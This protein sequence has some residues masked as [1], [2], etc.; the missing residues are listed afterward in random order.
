MTAQGEPLPEPAV[1]ASAYTQEYFLRD[2]EGYQEY[3]AS[4]GRTVGARFAHALALARLQHG[5]RVLD[6]GC[7]R[8]EI[9]V[10]AALRGA[11]AV[12]ID[13]AAAAAD[14]SAKALAAVGSDAGAVALASSLR[15]PFRAA[16]FDTV[17]LLDVV[18]H[19]V[20]E[21]LAATLAEVARVL[22]PGGRVIVHTSP[23]RLFEH[24]VYPLY[25]RQVHRAVLTLADLVRFHDGLLNRLMLPTAADF[26]HSEYEAL[27][28]SPQS[29]ASL[30][31]A[32]EAAGLRVRRLDFW[33]PPAPPIYQSRRLNLEVRLLDV[34]RYLRPLSDLAPLN[35][36]FKN[37]IWA[38]AERC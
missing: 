35:R 12:G 29:P 13:Y 22:R 34:V 1:P 31:R 32:L 36:L 25:V 5:E 11:R 30:S 38:V 17:F 24:V 6:I 19:L 8:G 23:N 3:A 10:Q 27:H 26:P 9:V 16:S 2:V 18:E 37:H 28:V 4:G 21:E 20:A 14:L 7:G 15:L 33:E